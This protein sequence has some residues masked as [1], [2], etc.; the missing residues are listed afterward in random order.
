VLRLLARSQGATLDEV[1]E[2][3]GGDVLEGLRASVWPDDLYFV[4]ARRVGESEV[5][6]QIA[7]RKIAATT[8]DFA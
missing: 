4:D 8:P 3:V 5:K 1:V 2:A 6:T 7:L